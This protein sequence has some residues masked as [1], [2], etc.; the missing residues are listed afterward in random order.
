MW[1]AATVAGRW[2]QA[3]NSLADLQPGLQASNSLADL[4]PGLQASNPLAD[5]WFRVQPVGIDPGIGFFRGHAKPLY[6]RRTLSLMKK[7]I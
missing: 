5:F 3:S 2:L 1:F 4:Q 7:R 6:V